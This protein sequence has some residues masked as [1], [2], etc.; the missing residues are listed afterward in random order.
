MNSV[1]VRALTVGVNGGSSPPAVPSVF[2]WKDEQSN[3]DILAMWHP[4]MS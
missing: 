3:S 4:G 1:G 2:V